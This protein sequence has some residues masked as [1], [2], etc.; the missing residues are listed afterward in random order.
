MSW[1]AV[2]YRGLSTNY[3]VLKYNLVKQL[4]EKT[5]TQKEYISIRENIKKGVE[6][7]RTCN[8]IAYNMTSKEQEN[9]TRVQ[10]IGE[11]I[12]DKVPVETANIQART[13]QQD[14]DIV[15]KKASNYQQQKEATG[16]G[17]RNEIGEKPKYGDSER[18]DL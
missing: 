11:T 17:Q 18:Q 13:K 7:K 14:N 16:N 5:A 8:K 2:E 12:E 10:N 6:S 4:A 9:G 3:V 1:A 15:T